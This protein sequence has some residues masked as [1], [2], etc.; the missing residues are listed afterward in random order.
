MCERIGTVVRERDGNPRQ[1]KVADEMEARNEDKVR[2]EKALIRKL[3]YKGQSTL[4][5]AGQMNVQI[6][7]FFV[8]SCHLIQGVDRVI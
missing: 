7:L 3:H 8:S 2:R 6:M 4:Q 1:A 5:S